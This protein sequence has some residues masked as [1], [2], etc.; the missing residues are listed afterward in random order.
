MQDKQK[1]H[2]FDCLQILYLQLGEFGEPEDPD[3]KAEDRA[4]FG[5]AVLAM[6]GLWPLLGC[7]IT[8]F[9][10]VYSIAKLLPISVEWLHLYVDYIHPDHS[11][12]IC[13][14][15]FNNLTNLHSLKIRLS[16]TGEG[17]MDEG[18][19]YITSRFWLDRNAK[20]FKLQHLHLYPSTFSVQDPQSVAQRLPQITHLAAHVPASFT[21][22]FVDLPVINYLGLKLSS[23]WYSGI[24]LNGQAPEISKVSVVVR[25]CSAVQRL[26]L[27]VPRNVIARIGI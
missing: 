27:D 4:S 2:Y 13:L 25:A 11:G 26:R 7:W 15:T 22:M 10:D 24:P 16:N 5:Q 21:Q 14:S 1:Q 8:G 19:R 23:S 18:D 17:S 12:L 9:C 3:D 20:L 6:A